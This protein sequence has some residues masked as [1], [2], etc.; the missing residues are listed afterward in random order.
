[1]NVKLRVLTAGAVF[2]IGAQSVVA[3]KV[4]KDSVKEIEEVVMV[5]FGQKKAVKEL[6]GAVGKMGKDIANMASGSID[7]AMSGRVAGVQMGMS[8]GQPGGAANIRIRGIA[9]VN[10][11][12]NPIIIIDGVRVAQGDLTVNTTTANILANLNEADIENVT[13]LK[14]AVSTAVYGAD[15]G[16][17]VVIITTKSGRKGQARFNFSSETGVSYRAVTGHEGLSTSEWRG[18]LA[19][20]IANRYNVSLDAASKNAVAGTYGAILKNIFNTNVSTDWRKATERVGGAMLQRTNLSVS[21]G[22]DR[23]TYYTSLGYFDQDGIAKVSSFKRISTSSRVNYKATDRLTISSDLQAS[24]GKTSTLTQGGAF[25]NPILGQYFLR[26]SDAL[27][28]GDGT[29]NLGSYGRLSNGLFNVAALQNLNYI[30]ASTARIFANLQT[31]YK[32]A[33]NLTYRFVFAPEYINIEEDDYRSPLHGDGYNL[34]GSLES[35]ATRYFNF[36]I[37]NILSYNFKL[38]RNSFSASLIQE[39]YRED[40]KRLGATANVVGTSNLQTL[41]SFIIPRSARGAKRVNSRGGYAATLHYDYDKLFLLDLSGRQ[42]KVSNFWLENRTGYF[43]S[44]GV[45]LDLARLEALKKIRAISQLKFSASYGSVGNLPSVDVS[46]YYTYYYGSNYGDRAGASPRGVDNKDLR[47]ETLN[48]MNIGFDMSLFNNRITFG[49]AYYNKTTRDMIFDLP[50]SMTQAGY[51]LIDN[52]AYARKYVNVG[53]MRNSGF[54]FTLGAQIVK[55]ENFSW[56]LNANFSTLD[57]KVLKLAEGKD[58]V[59]GTRIM[60]EGEVARAFYLRKWA[61]V[62]PANGAPLWYKNGVDGATTSNYNEAKE[63]VQGSPYAKFFGGLDTQLTYKGFSL[64]A[65]FSYGFGNKVFDYWTKF[66]MSDGQYTSTYPGY[67][68]QLDYWTVDNRNAKNPAPI[69]GNGNS[70]ANEAST[71]FLYKGDYVRLRTIKLSYTFDKN[72]LGSSNLGVSDIQLYVLGNNVWTHT[73]D[74]DF[75]FDPDLQIGGDANLT[76]PPMKSYSLGVSFN[77]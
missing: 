32:L 46:P 5:G 26:P 12:N 23:L 16:A 62:D 59:S 25:S 4:K 51:N 10:G 39:A 68:A 28:N 47:W 7:K 74:K 11:R 3:Q 38:N 27:L 6:T 60:R 14:D 55:N 56:S 48:P 19:Q 35:N 71:R 31:D 70:K 44:A 36:N 2:F 13:V 8:T 67:R 49:A 76:L 57:N 15:A 52:V 77:F 24:L 37:Q 54:E 29:Y 73:F 17:G 45:G 33:K 21:G 72:I 42:D 50:L 66:L 58:I 30:N 69:Y 43:W 18:L 40:R 1:M 53:S 65:Q 22:N 61:G 63:A 75:K 20:G 9:S 64:D 34:G 41:D